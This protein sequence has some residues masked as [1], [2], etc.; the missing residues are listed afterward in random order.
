GEYRWHYQTTPWETWD[1]T[2]TQHIMVADIEIGGEM[3]HV[4]MQAPKNGF[5]YV[6]D[7][8]TGELLRA[9]AYTEINWAT[10][11][12]METGRPIE[13][14]AARYDVTGVP[15]NSLPGPQGAHA[16][17]PMAFSPETQLLYIPVQD[18]WFYWAHD[19]SWEPQEVGFNLGVAFPPPPLPAGEPTGFQSHLRAMNP[20]TGE[21]VW[22]SDF[23][24]GPTGGALAT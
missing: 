22:S 12:D 3:R 1:Y 6:L 19:P 17:H 9:N 16:W 4:V 14:P 20:D 13:N 18:A 11:I 10:G 23:N 21:I 7:A 8:A 15:F 2:A 24:Q 5:L